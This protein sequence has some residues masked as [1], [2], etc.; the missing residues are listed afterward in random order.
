MGNPADV[1]APSQTTDDASSQTI[2][3]IQSTNYQVEGDISL[4]P[5]ELKMLIVALKNSILSTAMFNLF[6]VP[7]S[8]LS[9]AGSTA[10]YS[11]A[12][13]VITFI[14]VNEKKM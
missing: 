11:K 8:W 9:L 13:D 10:N 5:E 4:Y 14:L 12:M 2:M 6:A 3:K 7:L 1:V